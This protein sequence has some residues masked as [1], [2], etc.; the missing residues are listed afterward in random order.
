[1]YWHKHNPDY[2][3]PF[4]STS[5]HIAVHMDSSR[6]TKS[7]RTTLQDTKILVLC[8]YALYCLE[9]I[10]IWKFSVQTFLF[11]MSFISTLGN[12][13]SLKKLGWIKKIKQNSSM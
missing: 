7:K 6:K 1:M 10:G 9:I 3:P 12:V 8:P 4:L 11:T 5:I 2:L 13:E